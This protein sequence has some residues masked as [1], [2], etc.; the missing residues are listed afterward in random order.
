[1]IVVDSTEIEREI[2]VLLVFVKFSVIVI[3]HK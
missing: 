1:M 3:L 2:I